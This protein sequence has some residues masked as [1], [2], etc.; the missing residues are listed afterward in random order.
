[1]GSAEKKTDYFVLNAEHITLYKST[2][3]GMPYTTQHI[4]FLKKTFDLARLCAMFDAYYYTLCI[5]NED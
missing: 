2:Y 1:M 4:L 3:H 5:M